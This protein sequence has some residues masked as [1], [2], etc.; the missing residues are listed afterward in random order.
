MFQEEEEDLERASLQFVCRTGTVQ[1]PK[2]LQATRTILDV[3]APRADGGSI[4]SVRPPSSAAGGGVTMQVPKMQLPG[5]PERRG[6]SR[7]TTP[8]AESSQIISINVPEFQKGRLIDWV[9]FIDLQHGIGF[10][11]RQC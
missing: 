9:E 2:E 1:P 4:Q 3:I 6:G 7:S 8:R 5:Q 10:M 11:R